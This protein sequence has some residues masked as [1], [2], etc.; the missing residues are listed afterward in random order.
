MSVALFLLFAPT[1]IGGSFAYAIVNGNSMA[2]S[3]TT[4]D[5]VLLRSASDYAVGDAV[6]YRH[7]QIGP[8]LHRIIADDGQRFTLSGD[9]RDGNDSYNP[10]RNDVIGR[11]W[12]V[13]PR[14]GAVARQLQ[15]PRNLAL[16]VALTAMLLLG[17]KA[18]TR[19]HSRY[20]LVP[21]R[22]VPQLKKN[23]S[24]YSPYGRRLA[25]TAGGLA[26]GSVVLFVLWESRGPNQQ[27]KEQLAFAERG[28]FVNGG[29]IEGGVYDDDTLS[30]PEPL[31]RQLTDQLPIAFD[32][33]IETST[34]DAELT[35]ILGSY[36]LIAE[37][38]TADGWTRTVELQPTTRFAGAAFGTTT[39]I[40][41]AAFDETLAAVAEQT[42]VE[43]GT[44]SIRVIARVDV[45]GELAEIPFER[46]FQPFI[47][48]RLAPLQLQYE[49]GDEGLLQEVT[50]SVS[51]DS[52]APR[53]L[54][55]PM[56][57]VSIPY[58]KL[59]LTSA[60]LGLLAIVGLATVG[61]ATL[62]TWRGGEVARIRARYGALLID[63]GTAA[64]DGPP[65]MSVG[66]F[67][68]L[69]RLAAAEGLTV[70]H[71]RTASGEEYFV[72]ARDARW[73]YTNNK[74]VQAPGGFSINLIT[75]G[76]G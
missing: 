74:P 7:P 53:T 20:G 41:L 12:I 32:Y 71:R 36:D 16:L 5:I 29:V 54:E 34:A 37:I 69:A 21:R 75:T 56:L 13:I 64:D 38:G 18:R 72:T 52:V 68:D 30:A 14:G 2:P 28:E 42:G 67:V 9:N 63:I 59:P 49:S 33:S 25:I 73:R 48:F 35:N 17:A 50:G 58:S 55:L 60:A 27:I 1:T 31:Y 6:A 22:Y 19:R 66:N 4:N 40:D 26:L 76:D 15:T 23:V 62:I 70:M 8:V 47:Q 39:E 65:P 3:L 24:I 57:P 45:T 11:Q 10:T 43:A 61:T 46:G 44:Y 51:R